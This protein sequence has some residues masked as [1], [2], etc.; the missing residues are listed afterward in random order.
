MMLRFL[1][2]SCYSNGQER[3]TLADVRGL[4]TYSDLP[5][6]TRPDLVDESDA[7]HNPSVTGSLPAGL[8]P[9]GPEGPFGLPG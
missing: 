3:R 9:P 2:L 6:G 7:I 1:L 5:K 8:T 4:A